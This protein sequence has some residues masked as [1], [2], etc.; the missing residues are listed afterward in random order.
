MIIVSSR[1]LL[2]NC[3][4]FADGSFAKIYPNKKCSTQL[5]NTDHIFLPS[6]ILPSSTRTLDVIMSKPNFD[7]TDEYLLCLIFY[8]LIF[9][10][11][12]NYQ[13]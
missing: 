2:V 4:N 8:L 13:M 1:D 10:L 5:G 9:K 11:D 3:E 6:T 12:I 7:Y